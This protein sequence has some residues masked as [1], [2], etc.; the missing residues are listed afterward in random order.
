M[1][2]VNWFTPKKQ[3][4]ENNNRENGNFT[5]RYTPEIT[6]KL[7]LVQ[8]RKYCKVEYIYIMFFIKETKSFVFIDKKNGQSPGLSSSYRSCMLDG[9]AKEST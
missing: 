1:A 5:A 3:E 8:K 9:V 2:K 6:L 4:L 7:G